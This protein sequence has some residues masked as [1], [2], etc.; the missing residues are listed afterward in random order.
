MVVDPKQILSSAADVVLDSSPKVRIKEASPSLFS[1]FLAFLKIRSLEREF[2]INPLVMGSLIRVSK[3]CLDIDIDIHSANLQEAN[4]QALVKH[5][6]SMAQIVAIA[7]TNTEKEP[8]PR[9]VSYLIRNLTSS[10]LRSICTTVVNQ[11]DVKS[12]M[13]SIISIKGMSLLKPGGTIAHGAPSEA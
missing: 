1:R 12:F 6:K 13:I 4:Y 5:G 3:I 9:L 7:F 8:S 2:A 11:M 10:E